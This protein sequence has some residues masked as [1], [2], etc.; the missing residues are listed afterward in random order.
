MQI[1]AQSFMQ[2]DC[3]RDHKP[4]NFANSLAVNA[5]LDLAVTFYYDILLTYLNIFLIFSTRLPI[6]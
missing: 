4:T 1:N 6:T 2:G 3:Q 5:S